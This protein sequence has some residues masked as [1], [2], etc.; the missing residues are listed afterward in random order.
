MTVRPALAA[1]EA[2]AGDLA[3]LRAACP[4]PLRCV[5]GAQDGAGIDPDQADAVHR[6]GDDRG[7]RG[8]VL[9]ADRSRLLRVEGDGVG[10]AEELRMIEKSRPVSTIVTG[11]PAPARSSPSI[12]DLRQPPLVQPAAGPA[13]PPSPPRDRSSPSVRR[14][15]RG[16]HGGRAAT[17]DRSGAPEPP[18]TE[19]GVDSV[20]ARLDEADGLRAR[21]RPAQ[22]DEGRAP[23]ASSRRARRARGSRRQRRHR[24][25]SRVG[26]VSRGETGSSRSRM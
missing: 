8:A 2:A 17:V 18:E 25:K 15:P 19:L 6:G 3:R 24:V 1:A 16:A 14:R 5:P 23:G 12:A 20:R 13:C 10:A 9:P 7:D 26:K 21:R 11:T 4:S 22:P